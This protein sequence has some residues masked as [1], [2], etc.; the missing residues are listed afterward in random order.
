MLLGLAEGI[1]YL[2]LV[3]GAVFLAYAITNGGIDAVLPPPGEVCQVL[4]REAEASALN[5]LDPC[6]YNP[7]ICVR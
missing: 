4:D 6:T 5:A 3:A 1:A 7:S 2:Y